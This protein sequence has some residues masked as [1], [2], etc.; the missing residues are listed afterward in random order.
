MH[1]WHKVVEIPEGRAGAFAVVH[2]RKPAGATL[3]FSSMRTRLFGDSPT[4]S[5]HF[6][7]ET[8][9]HALTEEGGTWMTDLP[10]EQAQFDHQSRRLTTGKVLVGG[11]GIG[12]AV[13]A[14]ARRPDVTE[15]VVVERAHE[16]IDLVWK[17][18]KDHGKGTIVHGCVHEVMAKAIEKGGLPKFDA[19]FFDTWTFDSETTFLD[20]VLPLR[21][22]ADVLGIPQTRVVCWNE[23]VMRGQLQLALQSWLT[24][25]DATRRGLSRPSFGFP[26]LDELQKPT[27]D[28]YW[29]WR[30]P[31]FR[32][33]KEKS[34][35]EDAERF[36]LAA[37]AYAM[38]YGKSPWNG[39]VRG[40][41]VEL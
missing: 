26:T 10:I 18:V 4:G 24:L 1:P 19:A 27:G 7:E 33:V 35:H 40:I 20:E 36:M 3:E 11:L 37:R 9:W 41:G 38:T 31:F 15:I 21:E 2:K 22:R 14:L 6:E 32:V 13:N 25:E 8:T 28:K 30:V 12:Y 5:V 16:V 39:A 23:D 34:L 17:H 29:D